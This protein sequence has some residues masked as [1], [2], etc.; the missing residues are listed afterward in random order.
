MGE[1]FRIVNPAKQ[2]YIAPSAAKW[3][4]VFRSDDIF[5]LA[6]L[7]RE[8]PAAERSHPLLGSWA[9]DAIYVAGDYTRFIPAPW[10]ADPENAAF[11]N[12]YFIACHRYEPITFQAL[13]MLY[14]LEPERFHEDCVGCR[15]TGTDLELLHASAT[16]FR[17]PIAREALLTILAS[18]GFAEPDIPPKLPYFIPWEA[19]PPQYM[20]GYRAALGPPT[21]RLPPAPPSSH[22]SWCL[23]ANHTQ[24]CYVDTRAFGSHLIRYRVHGFGLRDRLRDGN[25]SGLS[26]GK[27]GRWSGDALSS[28]EVPFSPDAPHSPRATE[29]LTSYTD[30][31]WQFYQEFLDGF[32]WDLATLVANPDIV[33]D[34]ARAYLLC[35]DEIVAATLDERVRA[36]LVDYTGD[37]DKVYPGTEFANW[38]EL[39][40]V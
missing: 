14:T 1:Y 21:L 27:S 32:L 39:Y 25:R 3:C 15:A 16:R 6:L 22:N 2:Q 4:S 35:P 17:S 30:D 23:I 9:G 19:L 38:L 20:A 7:L 13:Q 29:I 10:N 33:R 5:A 18:A 36:A 34:M 40:G 26:K 8:V 28:V 11:E 37:K 24:K 12:L 31:T